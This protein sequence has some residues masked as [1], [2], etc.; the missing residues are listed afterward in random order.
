M[1]KKIIGRITMQFIEDDQG[2][3]L[4]G[5]KQPRMHSKDVRDTYKMALA[6]AVLQDHI[7]KTLA[8]IDRMIMN[9][10][11]IAQYQELQ[12]AELAS[13]PTPDT[14]KYQTKLPFKEGY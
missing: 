9:N 5:V 11:E 2:R 12:E 3:W 10:A 6:T 8:A 1:A 13:A 7:N 4:C 14:E